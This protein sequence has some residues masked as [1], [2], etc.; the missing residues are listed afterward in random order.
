MRKEG[1]REKE[2]SLK[3][4]EARNDRRQEQHAIEQE[5]S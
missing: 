1:K 5:E 2:S 4:T 3:K